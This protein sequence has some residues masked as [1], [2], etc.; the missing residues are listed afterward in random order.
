MKSTMKSQPKG[1]MPTKAAA[2]PKMDGMKKSAPMKMA[3]KK[4]K[5][6]RK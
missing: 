3:G 1:K 4:L 2:G 6:A 5:E